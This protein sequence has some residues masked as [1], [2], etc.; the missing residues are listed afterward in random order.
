MHCSQ[1]NSGCRELAIDVGHVPSETLKSGSRR[2]P[3]EMRVTAQPTR[4]QPPSLADRDEEAPGARLQEV[5]GTEVTILGDD[6]PV[7]GVGHPC[8]FR[9]GGPVGVRQ[10]V[11]PRPGRRAA[12]SASPFRGEPGGSRPKNRRSRSSTARRPPQPMGMAPA[13]G[14][15]RARRARACLRSTLSRRCRGEPASADMSTRMGKLSSVFCARGVVGARARQ[16]WSDRWY[17]A[18]ADAPV[19]R[20]HD[21]RVH[22][23]PVSRDHDWG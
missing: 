19:A 22:M 8:D 12:C 10:S 17:P 21:I 7:V 2:A 15:Q 18:R 6:D 3:S 9:V 23:S 16:G 4:C 11:T 1:P 14:R 13:R 20:H 5:A